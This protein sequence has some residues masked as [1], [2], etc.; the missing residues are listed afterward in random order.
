VTRVKRQVAGRELQPES[1]VARPLRLLAAT[2]LSAAARHAAERAASVAQAT[3]STL[4]LV[5]VAPFSQL[6]ELK[7][8]VHGLPDD[9][10]ERMRQQAQILLDSLAATLKEQYGVTAATH[11]AQGPLLKAMHDTASAAAA[12][13]LVLGAR[14]ASL[15]RRLALG[16]TAERLVGSF[17]R[18]MLVVKRA[19]AAPY[20][21]VLVP[22]DFSHASL[23]ALRLAHDVAP[24][25]LL[26]VMHAYEAPFEGK[27]LVAGVEEAD[28]QKYRD[29][30][31][32]EAQ[33]KL[34]ALCDEARLAPRQVLQVL[35]HG[36]VVRCILEQEDEHDCDLV[37]VGRS[38]QSSA[39][40]ALLGSVSRRLLEEAE[41]DVLVLP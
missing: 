19:P 34:R 22:V 20:R 4:D 8:L 14:G 30:A 37:A 32:S 25:A 23:P 16:S 28:L 11:V 26:V 35:V 41:S 6:D 13:L 7:R 21:R 10:A 9:V 33:E 2:D 15:L 12:D 39:E 40:D 27:L 18:P 36:N 24:Q 3:R 17:G 29:L 1:G 38:G 5:H 31:R